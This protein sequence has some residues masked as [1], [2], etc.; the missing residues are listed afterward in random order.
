MRPRTLRPPTHFAYLCLLRPHTESRE[1]KGSPTPNL[2]LPARLTSSA[3]A[4]PLFANAQFLAT[5]RTVPFRGAAGWFGEAD[6]IEVEPFALA[7]LFARRQSS[8]L[9][10]SAEPR[11]VKDG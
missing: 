10:V 8:V 9:F 2:L 6:A 7:L 4:L 5:V 1:P 11:S 3:D